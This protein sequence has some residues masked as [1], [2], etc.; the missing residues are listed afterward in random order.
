MDKPFVVLFG[1]VPGTSKSIIAH[2][3][4]CTYHL[5]I[6]ANDTLRFEIREDM[7]IDNNLDPELVVE[8]EKRN[9][10]RRQTMLSGKKPIIFDNSVDRS[11]AKQ[12]RELTNAGYNW[13]L[14]KWNYPD[15]FSRNYFILQGVLSS[16]TG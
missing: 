1:G 4:S 11:W 16:P 5:P 13:Y 3:L 10:Q 2:H 12:K 6:Y 8:F 9:Q 15:L 7:M 14:I